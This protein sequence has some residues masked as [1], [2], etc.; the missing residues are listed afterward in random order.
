MD[1]RLIF[2]FTRLEPGRL[3]L[4]LPGGSVSGGLWG[5]FE[6]YDRRQGVLL[7]VC[8]GDLRRFEMWTMLPSGYLSCRAASEAESETFSAELER[9]LAAV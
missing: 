3:Y 7:A 8:S 2:D 5:V 1:D 9:K 4:F 6:R